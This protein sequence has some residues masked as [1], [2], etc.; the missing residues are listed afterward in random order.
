MCA[1]TAAPSFAQ[2]SSTPSQESDPVDYETIRFDKDVVAVRTTDEITL[3]GLLDEPAWELAEPAIDFIQR[4]PFPGEPSPERSEVYFLYDEENLYVGWINFDSRA[5]EIRVNDLRED[6]AFR[7]TDS[8][9]IVIDSLHDLRS[10]FLFGTSPVGARRDSQ[11]SNDSS[12]NDDWDGDWDVKV[13]RNSDGW[14]A[15]FAIPFATLRFSGSPTQEWG[16]N[17]NRR[18]MRLNEESMWTPLP[19]RYSV[20]RMSLA[21]TLSGLENIRQGRNLKVTPYV[22]A[23]FT[24]S[25][26]NMFH[27]EGKYEGGVDLKYGLTPSLTLDA[28]YNTDF[29]QVEV[30]QQQ[31]NLSRFSLFFPEKRD[32]FLE[33]SGTFGFGSG[34]GRSAGPLVPF[35]SRRIGLNESKEIIPILG[36]ARVSGQVGRY[37]VGFLTMKTEEEIDEQ[38][39]IVTPSNNYIVGRIKRNLLTN[40]WIGALTTHRDSSIDGDTNRVYGADARFQFFDRLTFDSYILASYTPDR[41]GP[42][43]SGPN[44]ARQF[45]TTWRDDVLQVSAEY[46]SIQPDFNPEVGFVRRSDMTQYSGDFAWNPRVNGESIRNYRFETGLVYTRAA[47]TGALETREH[48]I[49][50]GIQFQDNSSITFSTRETFDRLTEPFDIRPTIAIPAGDYKYREYSVSASTDTSRMFS[51]SG[52]VEWGGFWDGD[53]TSVGGSLSLKP[54]YRWSLGLD[55]SHN[56]ITLPDGGFTTDLTGAR[57]VYGFSPYAFFNAF[58]QYNAAANR[59]SS[60]V[61]FNWTHSPLSDLYIV[62]NDIRDTNSGQLVERAVIV[63]FTNLFS[64]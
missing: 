48:Q 2:E 36:G 32:F 8:I 16:L 29:A 6:F 24:E 49:T 15:E 30:D 54:H 44:Q 62:Y 3:D 26:A 5:D 4:Q 64:F 20:N 1:V 53:R 55:Y 59:V 35:F 47:S 63:K 58:I 50:T 38:N 31:V 51:G 40:S 61:R 56:R 28:T 25:T 52:S 10:G 9:G 14:I 43:Q 23:G 18:I 17:M 7:G 34:N 57:F 22:T 37:D 13:T 46:L 27:W 45:G 39:R 12:F 60:N 41:S 11:I 42:N 21:G 19:V 33:N